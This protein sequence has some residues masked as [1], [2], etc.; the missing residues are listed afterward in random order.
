MKQV[1]PGDPRLRCPVCGT[2]ELV[3]HP[4]RD[5]D[6]TIPPDAKPP[7]EDSLGAPSYEVCSRCGFEFGFD[8]NPGNMMGD[9]FESYRQ[10][11]ESEGR[12][13]FCEPNQ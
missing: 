9:T 5:Y 11:W 8:D 3:C 1:T 13:R 7:Y 10:V 12:P 6:G 4:Y 2:H